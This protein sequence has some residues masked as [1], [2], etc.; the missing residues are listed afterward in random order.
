[1]LR[2][3]IMVRRPENNH[4]SNLILESELTPLPEF[5]RLHEGSHFAIVYLYACDVQDMPALRSGARGVN[6]SRRTDVAFGYTTVD[7][8][9]T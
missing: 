7:S 2:Y 1:M 4:F 9:V 3:P 6:Q 5:R 8:R